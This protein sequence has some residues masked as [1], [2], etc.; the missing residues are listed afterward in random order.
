M[1]TEKAT[2]TIELT[3]QEC[4]DIAYELS[5]SLKNRVASHWT[6]HL[7]ADWKKSEEE[8]INRIKMFFQLSLS[9]NFFQYEID[10]MDKIIIS[11]KAMKP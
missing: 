7:T 8:N 4:Y 5:A 1:K 9:P 10:A 2:Y 3:A 11:A 6:N